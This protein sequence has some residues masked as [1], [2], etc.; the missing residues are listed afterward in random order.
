M[1]N[2]G[3]SIIEN[4]RLFFFGTLDPINVLNKLSFKGERVSDKQAVKIADIDSF[5]KILIN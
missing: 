2:S 3:V 4:H 5:T 1:V